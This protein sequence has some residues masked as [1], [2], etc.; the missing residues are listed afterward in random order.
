MDIQDFHIAGIN[1]KKS[2]AAIRGRFALSDAAY[3]DVLTLAQKTGL[4]EVFVLSTCN[5]TEIYGLSATPEELIDLLCSKT[6]GNK[7]DFLENCYIKNGWSA[8]EHLFNVGAGLDS[9]ILG[10]YEIVAQLKLAAKFSKL[11]GTMGSFLERLVNTALQAS[12]EIKNKTELSVGTVSVA[13]AAVQYIKEKLENASDKNILLIGTGKIGRNTCRNLVDYLNT[14]HITLVNRTED[15]AKALAKELG[16]KHSS[17]NNLKKLATKSDVII[18]ATNAPSPILFKQDMHGC[19]EKILIDLSIP[20]NI[21][22]AVKE[23]PGI[24]LVNVDDLSQLNDVTLQKRLAE[25]PKAKQIIVKHIHEFVDWCM[26]R[27]NVP[28]LKAVKQKMLDMQTCPV[29]Q[30][31]NDG[32]KSGLLYDE[33]TIQQVINNMAS[34]MRIAHTPGCHFIEAINDFI[35][36]ET[37]NP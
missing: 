21:D 37:P 26:M 10:D 6:S 4:N 33:N 9:Q 16:I 14:K 2:D 1:Y 11:K 29:F 3:E 7:K 28:A 5:R 25:V 27:R 19:G 8:V 22:S 12:K 31:S 17:A 34:K 32:Y 20:N 24:S 30:Q 13:Y 18:V 23:L 15:S 35:Q 36:I